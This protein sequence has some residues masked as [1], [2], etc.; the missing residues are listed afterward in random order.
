[1]TTPLAALLDTLLPGDADW[2][3]AGTLEGVVEQVAADAAPAPLLAALPAGFATAD[4][5]SREAALRALEAAEPA[6]FERLVVAAYLAYYTH[7]PVRAVL[8]R[9]TGYAAHPPQPLGY[10]LPPFDESLLETQRKRAPF[11]RDA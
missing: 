11:W 1:M 9:L 5:E 7:D 8:E 10:E 2:P 4:A 6:A 3:A